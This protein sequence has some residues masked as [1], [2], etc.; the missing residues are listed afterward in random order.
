MKYLAL[1]TNIYLDMIVSRDRSH[2]PEA[3]DQMK[4]L[5]DFHEIKLVV[6]TVVIREID[7]NLH[8]E[9]KKIN[10]HLKMI[11]KH[12]E[13][14]Y[15]INNVD[16]M[17]LFN[18]KLPIIKKEIIDIQSMFE[19]N[20]EEYVKKAEQT[21]NDLFSHKN[22]IKINESSDTLLKA[23]YRQLYKMRPFH[24]NEPGKDS[25]AD[26]VIIEALIN[27][28]YRNTE[29]EDSVFFIS[30]NTKD[31]SSKEAKDQFHPEI[32][33]TILEH[34]LEER[35]HY[36]NFFYKTLTEEFKTEIENAGFY[37]EALEAERQEFMAEMYYEEIENSR[38]LAGLTSLSSD[39][40]EI[41]ANQKDIQLLSEKFEQYIYTIKSEFEELVEIYDDLTEQVK[42]MNLEESKDL[43]RAMN[44]EDGE[45]LEVI[46]DSIMDFINGII[47]MDLD[48]YDIDAV[49]RFQ[50]HFSLNTTLFE[51]NDMKGN[52][53]QI[54]ANG[55]LSPEN[56]ESDC[57]EILVVDEILQEHNTKG[58]IEIYYGF[59]NF[60]DNQASDGAQEEIRC[61]LES[62]IEATESVYEHLLNQILEK[63]SSLL[64]YFDVS[65]IIK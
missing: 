34:K 43:I 15:W 23:Q 9:I 6:P 53:F 19:D 42:L 49:M 56:G 22:V 27:F 17:M 1:D 46:H 57:V 65:K 62:V 63:K 58:S 4:R 59:L 7:R 18:E 44:L 36:S 21:F 5:L 14:L 29:C 2:K 13:T 38:D 20:M 61:N 45:T 10:D 54:I 8:N 33:N 3:Y 55:D 24:Y 25:M 37:E 51:L 16:E 50:D 11:K 31:F 28:V 32:L 30:R 47:D 60:E 40:E 12:L 39:W 52:T 41:I 26:A 48:S 35:F 64:A